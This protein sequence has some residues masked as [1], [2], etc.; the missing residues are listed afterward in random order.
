MPANEFWWGTTASSVGTEGVA[1]TADWAAW[2]R[3]GRAPRSGDGN[4]FATSYATD[5]RLLAERGLVHQRI[6]VEWARLEP[7]PGHHDDDAVEH[8]RQVLTT[9]RQLGIAPWVTL[10]HGSLP[11]WFADDE[12]GFREPVNVSAT[13]ARHVD[14]CA[15]TFE[16]LAAGWVPIEDPVG[17]ALRGHALGLRP[18]GRRDPDAARYAVTGALDATFEA[19]RLLHSGRLPVMAVFGLAIVRPAEPDAT[20]AARFLDHLLW[21]SWTGAVRDGLYALPWRAPVERPDLVGAFDLVGVAHH[22]PIG[23]LADTSRTAWP[24]GDRRDAT[25]FAPNPEELGEL[26]HRV[27]DETGGRPL[28]VAADGVATDDDDWRDELLRE[29]LRQLAQVRRDGLDVRGYFHDTGIDGYE[30]ELGFHAPRGLLERDRTPKPSAE[31]L[32]TAART[33]GP[34]A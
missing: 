12:R 19:W 17:W 8:Y 23:V 14:F 13:W 30:W 10:H 7:T 16:D 2:E 5:L 4:G 20:E 9:A 18:P 33:G 1:P 21:R 25:G 26:L 3:Q 28:V 11:G 29:T 31:R 24:A 34:P 6:T 27:A 15:E 32:A 22:P